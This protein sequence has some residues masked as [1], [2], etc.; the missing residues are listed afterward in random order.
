[1]S[2][3][4]SHEVAEVFRRLRD[5]GTAIPASRLE[6]RHVVHRILRCRTAAL[7]GH[8][9]ACSD[10]G[11]REISYNSCRDR[12]CPKCQGSAQADWLQQRQADVLPVPYAHVVFTLPHELGPLALEHPRVLYN[13]L[14]Q[15][16]SSTLLD[17]AAHPR[18]LG[19]RIGFFAVLH[20][21]GQTLVHHPHLHCVVPAG[22]LAPDGRSWVACSPGFFLP[23]RVLSRIFRARYLDGLRDAHGSASFPSR[24][25]TTSSPAASGVCSPAAASRSRPLWIVRIHCPL[26]L[27]IPASPPPD[28]CPPH[29]D[30][31][32]H[33]R[34]R[35]SPAS[36]SSNVPLRSSGLP[37]HTADPLSRVCGP[38]L[39]SLSL[40]SPPGPRRLHP[41]RP[42]Y[43]PPV[44][45]N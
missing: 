40:P 7:G 14:F 4:P 34:S 21:W 33:A 1:M 2:G 37:M 36:R 13:L 16:A 25:S 29:P 19:A 22:G 18:F 20:T 41:H 43:R 42:S 32:R 5:A 35:C 23:V 8:V 27:P 24:P 44:P 12:H 30:S 17:V 26:R 15:A 31:A 6:Q 38:P 28:F 10:C 3:Q 45:S 11:H 39:R 9:D